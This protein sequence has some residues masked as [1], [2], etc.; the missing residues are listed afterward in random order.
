MI[1]KLDNFTAIMLR[2]SDGMMM[3]SYRTNTLFGIFSTCKP[4]KDVE[5]IISKIFS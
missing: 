1:I 5:T 2:N 3:W 4:D